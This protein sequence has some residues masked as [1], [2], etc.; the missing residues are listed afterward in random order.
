MPWLIICYPHRRLSSESSCGPPGPCR[1]RIP[2]QGGGPRK[3]T[4]TIE[5]TVT[6]A[7]RPYLYSRTNRYPAVFS[8]GVS[9]PPRVALRGSEYTLPALLAS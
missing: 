5:P 7:T 1:A 3:V 6:V 9:S 2:G 8:C 4:S